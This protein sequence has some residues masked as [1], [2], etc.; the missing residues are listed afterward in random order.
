[1]GWVFL[2]TSATSRPLFLHLHVKNSPPLKLLLA[3]NTTFSPCALWP[4][5]KVPIIQCIH[6]HLPL[7]LPL[8][9]NSY[10]ISGSHSALQKLSLHSLH[11]RQ[12]D[13]FININWIMSSISIK[14]SNGFPLLLVW[15]SHSHVLLNHGI[16][17]EKPIV[18]WY[19]HCVK[20]LLTKPRW[21]ILL[22][23]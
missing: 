17:S 22:F 11:S 14:S 18:R 23:T 13:I 10:H 5:S 21:S 15:S 4:S 7:C 3:S 2:L 1:M 20:S 6:R 16:T 9:P 12:S 8:Y 19:H